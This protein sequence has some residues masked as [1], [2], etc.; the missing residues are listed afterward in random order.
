VNGTL[1]AVTFCSQ[2]SGDHTIIGQGAGGSPT[3]SAVL[4]D[5]IDIRAA[6]LL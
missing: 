2:H 4:R 6:L 5:L 3:A 1:N